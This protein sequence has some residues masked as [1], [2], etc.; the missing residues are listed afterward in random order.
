[1]HIGTIRSRGT[2]TLP[3]DLRKLLGLR[4]GDQ[5]AFAVD[6]DRLTITP[7]RVIPRDQAWFWSDNWQNRERE[8]DADIA[9]GRTRRFD[10]DEELLTAIEES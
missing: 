4:E 6:D 10:T 1:M 2:T 8:A 7:I 3:A 9:A 5:V